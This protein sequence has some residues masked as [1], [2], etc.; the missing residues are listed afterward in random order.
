MLL[1]VGITSFA[2]TRNLDYYIQQAEANSPLINQSKN[3]NKIIDLDIQKVRSI[4]FKPQIDAD[5]NLLFAPIISHDNNTNKLQLV[6]DGNTTSY[7]GYDM[8]YSDGG[9]YNAIVSVSQPLFVK[10]RFDALTQKADI[11]SQL[12]NNNITITQHELVQLVSHQYLLCLKAKKQ[13][14]LSAI[15]IK[16]LDNQ[17]QT[18]QKLVDNAIYKKTD[19]MVMHIEKE[20]FEL[21]FHSFNTE[22]QNN[23]ADLNLLCGIMDTSLVNIQDVSFKLSA[24]NMQQS[25]FLTKYKLDSLNIL[26][27]ENIFNQRYKPQVNLYANAGM[28]AIYLPSFNRFGFAAGINFSLKLFDGNQREIEH[29]KTNIILQ[30]I[31][32]EKQNFITK[33]NIN[34]SKYL[35]QIKLINNQLSITKKQLSEYK[36]LMKLFSFE[37]SQAQVSIMDY[38]NLIRDISAKKQEYLLLSMKKQA[39]I[40]WFN[41][42]NY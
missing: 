18:M 15:L 31:E 36:N 19:L 2:Q 33:N 6:S 29:N 23:I 4:L 32:F 30:N 20:N 8:A 38:K 1:F 27:S 22:Y 34:K 25:Y 24:A 3:E 9:Q 14:E 7:T 10:S 21:E 39:M 42:W 26:S 37:L 11:S 35:K 17:I 12:N 41:Y 28:N 13:S 16:K 5:A 40:N